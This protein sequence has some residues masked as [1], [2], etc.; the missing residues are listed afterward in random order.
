[1]TAR[2]RRQVIDPTTAP[3]SSRSRPLHRPQRSDRASRPG[4][5]GAPEFINNWID[6]GAGPRGILTLVTCAKARALLYGR[7]HA[8]VEDVDAVAKPALRHR[9]ASNYAAH[10][11][12]L[13][14]EALIDMLLDSISGTEVEYE[15]PAA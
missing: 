2:R 11:Q 3:G 7:Y 5:E 15:Q 4:A 1:M 6:W 8:T 12:G 13:D 10:A 14:N 9:I